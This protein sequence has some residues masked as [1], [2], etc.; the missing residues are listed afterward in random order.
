MKRQFCGMSCDRLAPTI[1]Q[2]S[3]TDE[4]ERASGNKNDGEVGKNGNI[5]V[6]WKG[7]L[8]TG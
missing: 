3:G 4:Q 5:K 7:S 8:Y 1:D 6:A 2:I